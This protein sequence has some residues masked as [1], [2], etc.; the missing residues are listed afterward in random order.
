[1]KKVIRT[2]GDSFNIIRRHPII[3]SP[4][5]LIA[6]VNTLFLYLLYLAPQ[7]PVSVV[8]APPIKVFFG[9]KFLHYPLNLVLMPKLFYYAQVFINAT[10]GVVLSALA[11][12]MIAK[13]H[14]REKPS[15]LLNFI[16]TLKRYFSLFVVWLIPFILASAAF[17][18]SL[19]RYGS[20]EGWKGIAIVCA[21]FL[22]SVLVQIVFIYA[23]P[24]IIIEKK[25]LFSALGENMRVVTKLFAPT[26]FLVMVPALLYL[27]VLALKF[28]SVYLMK[29]FFPEIVLVIL[30]GGVLIS[31]LIDIVIVTAVTTLFLKERR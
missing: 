25:N 6:L 13:V 27:P 5:I 21:S 20:I 24:L 23:V 19:T 29:T 1:M 31:L 3:I 26:L 28:K 9:E 10:L 18:F 7:R 22:L 15:F 30:M 17:K 8:L 2:W 11:V 14:K 12:L 4:F 16:Q